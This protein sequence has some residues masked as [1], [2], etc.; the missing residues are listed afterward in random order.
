MP[1]DIALS[2][3]AGTPPADRAERSALKAKLRR[4]E[5]MKQLKAFGLI[6]PL[7]AFL[8]ITFVVPIGDMMLRSV[9]DTELSEVW[10]RTT[11]AIDQWQDRTA[12]PP[13]AVYA[14][15]A[16]D[17]RQSREERT[18]ATA[19]RRLNYDANGARTFVMGTARRLPETAES[20]KQTLIDIDPAW[21]EIETFGAIDRAS[22]PFTSFFLLSAVDMEKT[23]SGEIVSA[24]EQES[25]YLTIFTRT[26]VI[27]TMVT[28]ICLIMGF[29][30]AYLLANL[31]PKQANLLMI[32]VLLPFWTSLLV[33][34]AAWVVLLQEQGLINDTLRFVGVIDEPIRMIYNRIGVYIA[35]VHIL[36]PFMI[37]PLY[38][39]MKGIKPVY[40]KAA[41]SLGAPPV[42]A[43]VRVYLPQTLPGISAGAL[44]V[45]IISIGYYITPAL[46][47]GA[48][49]QMISY[50]IAFYTSD[51]VNWGM[52]SA[53]GAVLLVATLI[54]YT[55][56][57][58]LV[59][60]DN[61]RMG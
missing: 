19:A 45:F 40:L 56:Y 28:L 31:P 20:W 61:I 22:G 41:T 38:S 24:P 25:V 59:G 11:A 52:A 9:H 1:S 44:L 47:G 32:M 10:P 46:V 2:Q 51:T 3:A 26:F 58:R 23:A 13:E 34:T 54:L 15:L 16:E 49:D 7:L 8:L 48:A 57:N 12:L 43:F 60:A 53:L 35:M 4:A 30:V 37:L 6:A 18:I 29:P 50:F 21:G 17:M 14:A 39:V 27:S 36:L 5:R 42:T 33:R 55:V